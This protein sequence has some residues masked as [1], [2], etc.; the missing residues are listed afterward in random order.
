MDDGQTVVQGY[1]RRNHLLPFLAL[2]PLPSLAKAALPLPLLT[3]RIAL[4]T[5]NTSS[6]PFPFFVAGSRSSFCRMARLL[7]ISADAETSVGSN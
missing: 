4:R 2:P 7:D 1:P 5:F 3:D 6:P